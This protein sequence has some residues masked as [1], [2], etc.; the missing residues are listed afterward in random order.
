MLS[1]SL[2]S[3]RRGQLLL[4]C[5]VLSEAYKIEVIVN[6]VRR[7]NAC[8]VYRMSGSVSSAYLK[9]RPRSSAQSVKNW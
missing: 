9:T 6:L 4:G 1:F 3:F 7:D 5:L 8:L 2:Q